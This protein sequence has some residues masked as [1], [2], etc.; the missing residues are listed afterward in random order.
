M[1]YRGGGSLLLFI[2]LFPCKTNVNAVIMNRTSTGLR[3]YHT[4]EI[5]QTILK[6]LHLP[7]FR[8]EAKGGK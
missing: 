1:V 3:W 7:L 2:V 8:S 6:A 5:P 4:Q